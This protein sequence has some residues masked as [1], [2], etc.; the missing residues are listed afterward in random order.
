M[1]N[2]GLTMESKTMTRYYEA[3]AGTKR[4]PLGRIPHTE[5]STARG[6]RER[7]GFQRLPFHVRERWARADV[8][9]AD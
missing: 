4:R 8:K 3:V 1:T 6:A 5:A 2:E 9:S 7:A